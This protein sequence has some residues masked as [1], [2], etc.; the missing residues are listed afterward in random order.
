[1]IETGFNATVGFDDSIPF[2][3]AR[4]GGADWT[5]TW[6]A[7]R[8]SFWEPRQ[9]KLRDRAALRL[10]SRE[11]VTFRAGRPVPSPLPAPRLTAVLDAAKLRAVLTERNPHHVDMAAVLA[12]D[13]EI[14]RLLGLW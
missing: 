8:R 10:R 14:L 12:E 2:D 5:P 6:N 4:I 7:K 13:A 3:G 9:D 11:A 1:M